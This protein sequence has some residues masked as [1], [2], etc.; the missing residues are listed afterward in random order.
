MKKVR[1]KRKYWPRSAEE[2]SRYSYRFICLDFCN[3]E[4]QT[5][6][7]A[8]YEHDFLISGNPTMHEAC[9]AYIGDE[10]GVHRS[11]TGHSWAMHVAFTC[12]HEVITGHAGGMLG[13]LE[14][15]KLR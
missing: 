15:V 2:L 9:T 4:K 1:K 6:Q 3:H 12:V 5:F 13:V 11:C 8:F 10:K 7:G 14:R